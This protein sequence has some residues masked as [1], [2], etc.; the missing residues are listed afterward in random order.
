MHITKIDMTCPACFTKI[1]LWTTIQLKKILFCSYWY[2]LLKTRVRT[3][4]PPPLPSPPT[5]LNLKSQPWNMDNYSQYPVFF[6]RS[7]RLS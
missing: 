3:V 4:D 6:I 1:K 7:S 5:R 2:E